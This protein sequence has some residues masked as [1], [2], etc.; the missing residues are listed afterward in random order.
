MRLEI[1]QQLKARASLSYSCVGFRFSSRTHRVA[2]S[3]L[4]FHFQGTQHPFRLLWALGIHTGYTIYANTYPYI[5]FKNKSE[6]FF[7]KHLY[8]TRTTKEKAI[9]S[10]VVGVIRGRPKALEGGVIGN[11]VGR[12]WGLI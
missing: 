5:Y 7:Y 2:P 11:G 6:N 1:A 8:Y 9:S 4:Q 12:G 10:I 3:H